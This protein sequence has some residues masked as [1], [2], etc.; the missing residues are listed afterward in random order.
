MFVILKLKSLKMK[1]V[2]T[3]CDLENEVTSKY[4]SG[5]GYSLPKVIKGEEV[6]QDTFK[7]KNNSK[8][9]PKGITSIFVAL[10]SCLV[11]FFL[12]QKFVFK[13]PTLDKEMM[14]IANEIN[15]SCPLMLDKETRLDNT[16]SMPNNVFQY[17]YTLINQDKNLVDVTKF[18]NYLEPRIINNIKTS[19]NLKFQRE[20]NT[21]M[22]YVYKDRSGVFLFEII[23]SPDKY[24]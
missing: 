3:N 5:C 24:N 10:V 23:I 16:I 8:N 13:A 6:K 19:P 4:C 21:T 9:L 1:V 12:V 20:H 7:N 2:C 22:N 18:I 11:S 17:N 14:A 15:K